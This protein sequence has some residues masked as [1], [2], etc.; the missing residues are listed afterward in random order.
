MKPLTI[1]GQSLKPKETEKPT[2]IIFKG[3]LG[4]INRFFYQRSWTDG[5]PVIP[6]TEAAAQRFD[7]IIPTSEIKVVANWKQTLNNQPPVSEIQL[8]NR[9]LFYI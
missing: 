8:Q 7:D 5:L 4:E 2:R 3:S 6:P 9:G 1:E